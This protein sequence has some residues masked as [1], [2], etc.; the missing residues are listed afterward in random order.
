MNETKKML[1]VKSLSQL[2]GVNEK[3][4]YEWAH[5]NYLPH[6]KLGHLIRFN[7][8][9]VAKWLEEKRRPGAEN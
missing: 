8:S 1:N 6:Y 7:E 4:I 9:E 2:I 3:T 5:R